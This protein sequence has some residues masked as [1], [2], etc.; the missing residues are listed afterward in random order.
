[1]DTRT[2]TYAAERRLVVVVHSA[3]AGASIAATL[4]LAS[5]EALSALLLVALGCFAVAVP[6]AIALVLLSQV[7]SEL[8]T[9]PGAGKGLEKFSWPALS[10]VLAVADQIACYLGFLAIFWHFHWIVGA[11]FLIATLLAFTTTW[12][13]GKSLRN[14]SEMMAAEE[15]HETVSPGV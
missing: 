14:V 10:Y 6:A 8:D 13:A 12:M 4:E 7:I 15:K 11:I 2:E 9:V 3:I 5:R 1:M